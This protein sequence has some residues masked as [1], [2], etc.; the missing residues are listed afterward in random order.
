MENMDLDQI[1]LEQLRMKEASGG[2]KY[3]NVL[4]PTPPPTKTPEIEIP[5]TLGKASFVNDTPSIQAMES[6]WKKM[7][8][9][10]L[11]S[12]AFGYPPGIEISIRSAE[13]GEIRHFSTIDEN[14]PIDIDDKIN[15]IVSKCSSVRWSE[16]PLSYM[17][18]Y[19]EDRFYIFMA[20]RD[21]TFIKGENRIFIPT[22]NECK[23]EGCPIPSE[24]ELTSG[25]LSSF[26]LDPNV[27][28]YY[29][30]ENGCFLLKPKNGDPSIQLFIPTIGVSTNIRKILRGKIEK[31]KKYDPVFATVS[32]YV[33]P[34]WR[35]L[36]ERIYDEYE[37]YSKDWTYTQFVLAD[38][39]TKQIT[40]ATKN[41]LSVTCSK[42]SAEVAAPIRFRGGIRSLYI[43]S[44]IFGQLL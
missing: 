10:N 31:N 29:D 36:D 12:E 30:Q 38:T 22:Q 27:K 13:V 43:I 18:L 40:F 9:G 4:D 32:P 15:H 44:D 5:K 23:T 37:S 20:I 34:N 8:L 11:P 3:D 26:K 19:Q 41:S 28:K 16:G 7:P 25:I 24:I 42:C 33:I 6:P 35:E 2:L 14:D 39:I 1:A 17:D 21:L